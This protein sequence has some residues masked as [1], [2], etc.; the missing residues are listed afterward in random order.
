MTNEQII[1]VAG[2]KYNI[3]L[4]EADG[5]LVIPCVLD[6]PEKSIF[7]EAKAFKEV[8]GAIG[9]DAKGK[10]Y[11]IRYR[12]SGFARRGE[13]GWKVVRRNWDKWT[14]GKGAKYGI[15]WERR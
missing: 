9:V 11:P 10:V 15:L 14:E 1:Q 8:L 2:D 6:D 4:I 13:G 7:K 3:E 5:H 12:Y